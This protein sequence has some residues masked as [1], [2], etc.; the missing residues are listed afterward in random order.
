MGIARVSRNRRLTALASV[1]VILGVGLV[2]VGALPAPADDTAVS[3]VTK[4]G[5][6][7]RTG[8]T[9]TGGGAAGTA[10]PGDVID[11]VLTYKNKTGANA[12]VSLNDTFTANQSY[13][14]DSLEQPP[15]WTTEVTGNTVTGSAAN[16]APDGQPLTYIVTGNALQQPS[17]GD[18]F[19]AVFSALTPQNVYTVFH[20]AIPTLV[21]VTKSGSTCAGWGGASQ[22][23]FDPANP[24]GP[25][26]TTAP[27]TVY[28]TNLANSTV[29][30]I[31]TGRVY[32]VTHLTAPAGS[33][34][35]TTTGIICIDTTTRTGC[36][37][38][39]TTPGLPATDFQANGS[40]GLTQASDGLIY[41]TNSPA[42]GSVIQR[43]IDPD[44]NASC[45]TGDNVVL[46]PPGSVTNPY[47]LSHSRVANTT[48][49][50]R[51]V[52][53]SEEVI[54]DS[55]TGVQCYDTVTKAICANWP[56]AGV[57]WA[58][59][60][61]PEIL[62]ILDAS[63]V[64]TGVC[65]QWE[66]N[67][68]Q[69]TNALNMCW[70][71][72]TAAVVP[73]P[74]AYTRFVGTNFGNRPDIN[75]AYYQEVAIAQTTRVYYSAWADGQVYC[76]DF[77]TNAACA[78][79]NYTGP[80]F[81][82]ILAY[83]L[84]PDPLNP[85]CL[86]ENG[87]RGVLLPINTLTGGAGCN[88]VGTGTAEP[89]AYYC[90]GQARTPAWQDILFTAPPSTQFTDYTVTIRDANDAI[91]TDSSGRVWNN[92]LVPS[93]TTSLSLANIGYGSAWSNGLGQTYDTTKLTVVV[94]INGQNV[95]ELNPA[96][97]ATI[98]WVGGDTH[99]VCFQTKVD[100]VC[101]AAGTPISNSAVFVTNSTANGGATDAPGGNPSGAATFNVTAPTSE[102]CG[103]AITKTSTES[104]VRIG[105][106]IHYTVTITNNGTLPW[107]AANPA[108]V[109]DDLTDVLGVGTYNDDAQ[110]SSG[111]LSYDTPILNWTGAIAAGASVTITYSVTT[112]TDSTRAS[113]GG[114][115]AINVVT[116]GPDVPSN[117]QAP[118]PDENCDA[119]VALQDP[120]IDLVKSADVTQVNLAGE[121]VRY[122]FL[123][124]NTGNVA[125]T[126]V[127]VTDTLV[128][129]AGPEI[130]VTCP[131]TSLAV[132]ASMTCTGSPYVVTQADVDNGRIDNSA[133]VTGTPPIGGAV[134]D[135]DDLMVPVTSGAA[136]AVEKSGDTEQVNNAGDVIHYSFLVTNTG[137]VTL[138]DVSVDD[139]FVAPAGPEL[140][141]TC[142]QDTL[143]P[144][145]SMTCTSDPYTVT[146]AD[147]NNGAIDNSATA[148]GTPPTGPAVT[149]PESTWHV[150]A[151]G[152]P[153]IEVEK[154]ADVDA[155]FQAGEVVNYTFVV[156][157]TGNVPLTDVSVADSLVAPAGPEITVTCPST[158]LAVGESMTC[159]GSPYTVTQADIDHGAVDNS[160][161][162]TGRS[163]D[164]TDVTDDDDLHLGAPERPAITIVKSA[165]VN[166]VQE[167]GDVITYSFLVTN[168]GTVTLHDVGVADQLHAPA[169]PEIDVTCPETTLAPG[170]SMTCTGSPYVAKQAD[171][172]AGTI[173]NDATATGTSPTGTDVTDTDDLQVPVPA[174]PSITVEKI[175]DVSR[176][177]RAGDVITYTF[178]VVNDGN[179]TLSGIEL[180][181]V[182]VAP[183]G[184]EIT[185]TCPQTTL[186]A[187]E[188]MTCTGS[189]YVATQADVDN[190]RID[191][192]VTATGTPPTG[193]DVSDE[194]D[195]S[196]PAEQAPA[197][198]VTKAADPI[199][200]GAAGDT[201]TY[202]FV[203]T[204]T[205]NLTLD[206]VAVTDAL[207]PPAGPEIDVI[208]PQ[209][210]LAPA[211]SMTCTSSPYTVTQADVDHGTID[212]SATATGTPPTGPPV[213]DDDLERVDV[214]ASP[215]LSVVKTGNTETV[216]A[217]GDVV[218]Y[219]F[220]VT[221][222]G[223]VTMSDISV[224]DTLAPPAGPELEVV[225]PET[226]LAPAE[227]MTCTASYTVTQTDIDHGAVDNSA[228][229]TGTPPNG[230]PVTTPDTRWHV[231][232]PD[233]PSIS[234]VKSASTSTANRAGDVITYSFLV[235][236]TG[237]LTLTDVRVDDV[238]V[239]PA[240]PEIEVECPGDTLAPDASMTCVG[241]YTV[242]QA[243]VDHGRIDNA[244]TATGTDPS[245]TDVTSPE[246]EW[247][248]TI[249]ES[250]GIEVEKSAAEEEIT[251]A[252]Q[253]IHYSFVVTNTGNV[254]LDQVTVTDE[255]VDP[256][257]PDFDVTCPKTTLT[258]G[259]EMTCTGTYTT[260]QEDVDHGRVDNT[261]T[262]TGTSPGGTEVS[263][264][265]ELRVP[266]ES[267][268]AISVVKQPDVDSVVVGGQ[269]RYTFTVT[270]TGNQT[271]REITLE[272]QL[273]APAGPQVTVTCP[274]TTLAPD[275]SMECTST[276]YRATQADLG[277]G[278][279]DNTVTVTG[280]AP[281]GTEVD[282]TDEASVPVKAAGPARLTLLKKAGEPIDVNQN[283]RADAGDQIQYTF[284]V[285]NTGKVPVT[286][287][288]VSDPMLSRAGITITCPDQDLAPGERVTCT[289]SAA[290]TVTADDVRRT[291]VDNTATA[292]GRGPD[293]GNSATVTSNPSS[294]ST[295]LWTPIKTGLGAGNGSGTTWATIAGAVLVLLGLGW[296][297]MLSVKRRRKAASTE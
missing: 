90:D 220:L 262:A 35:T 297:V 97:A 34:A 121:V 253:K 161:T 37:I 56:A 199:R 111:T 96:P 268:P 177:F 292:S 191:N 284:I 205:G 76:W 241:T 277:K 23:F 145:A 43:C 109:D 293:G 108:S 246:S 38:L 152:T 15:G 142:P 26:L 254:T 74:A 46:M 245:G 179:V 27:A 103:L 101:L 215:S 70:S 25:L 232:G 5:T 279:V 202:T 48:A 113:A 30:D 150:D 224:T 87:D 135:D 57:R 176:F 221:N 129:P 85:N 265:D 11:W 166:V 4:T 105:D 92:S 296:A 31:D 169:T 172:D 206:D 185:I 114:Y 243:D 42:D 272:D 186:A 276:A 257:G 61:S 242:T 167:V 229:A 14:A 64:L 72:A 119:I 211:E 280:T 159:T 295:P 156:R 233:T 183:A 261:V 69:P 58:T 151:P 247:A 204:N 22:L 250:P 139:T 278:R 128:A 216:E 182:L 62:P 291:R 132:G 259:E 194:D 256:A 18:G 122:T 222:T 263:D 130:T 154:S 274:K 192:G 163:P 117:C 200:V 231:T 203:V 93:T 115:E 60:A 238:L 45:A 82:T 219:E 63:G 67:P 39:Q 184:P 136:I 180:T 214:T 71:I 190:G 53:T 213:T 36:G 275:E 95:T 143:A 223:N 86:W 170:E 249:P 84:V 144:G 124:T 258:P 40:S 288:T 171:V 252:G 66:G 9:V 12:R 164:G 91:I 285:T 81:N 127:S 255:L 3:L 178:Q 140:T 47:G 196:V 10:Q 198:S 282:D 55:T 157:N 148:T 195:L 260:T 6:N 51:Y 77:A 106:D 134:T 83:T 267:S 193:D 165:D 29:G 225:C 239:A 160:A 33:P 16:V 41:W 49:F 153:L 78:G 197:I 269:I 209:T 52:I 68:T 212:N 271:L 281:G 210:T 147:V 273:A 146:Q 266:G 168:T 2:P 79:W 141:V 234:L 287:I 125:L 188:G 100:S 189:P 181:D 230:G 123:V 7:Q 104:A 286:D 240:G 133:S 174:D 187:G 20:H 137:N 149:S 98:R 228:I 208:C 264:D 28:R 237:P 107:T 88:T 138:T 59:N 175:S 89:A 201:V 50:G 120:S 54:P 283:G 162:A 19:N 126:D 158:T 75:Q 65:K 248:V 99:Q 80:N 217:A 102:T 251:E 44:T 17:G 8:E 1:A 289:A 236:N 94:S 118:T 227:S 207:V 235:T 173:D 112:T 21:C 226:T 155:V 24:T 294:T 13:V 244:A 32:F 110:A 270:N 73:A 116:T 290:Y 218:Q 131:E